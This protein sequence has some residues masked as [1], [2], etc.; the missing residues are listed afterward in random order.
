MTTKDKAGRQPLHRLSWAASTAAVSPAL[1]GLEQPERERTPGVSADPARVGA[2]VTDHGNAV[3][4]R[5][6]RQDE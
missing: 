6:T 2:T 3:L 4:R 5:C 1:D